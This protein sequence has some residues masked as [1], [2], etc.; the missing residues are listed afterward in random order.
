MIGHL[1]SLDV[2]SANL[3]ARARFHQPHLERVSRSFAF[4]I[5]RLEPD[6]RAPVGLGY[7]V[8][9]LLD[10]IEDAPWPSVAAQL[11]AFDCFDDFVAR[12]DFSRG[13]VE[14]WAASF[15]AVNEGE[16]LL[17]DD[18][19]EVFTELASAPE[20]S[21]ML[22]PILSMSRGMRE[23]A[24][25]GV[26]L[27][28]LTDVNVYCFFVAGV[29]GE[30]LTSL[31]LE[32]RPIGLWAEA[33][34]FG[35][36]LQKINVLKD[37][38]GDEA[39]GRFL[40]P[41]RALLIESVRAHAIEAFA[42]LRAQTRRDYRLFC[43]WALY[44]G[45][46]TIPR[47][48]RGEQKL[49]RLDALALGAKLELAIMDNAR[50]EDLFLELRDEAWPAASAMSRET[51]AALSSTPSHSADPAALAMIQRCYRGHLNATEL[52]RLLTVS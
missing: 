47:L 16:R 27:T 44:L 13:S 34:H 15:P 23:F 46:A 1:D 39:E 42:Y 49:S 8:C 48:R 31:A 25:R 17:L 12:N 9:R 33:T 43:A 41:D 51:L 26:R 14:A 37:Q 52:A 24:K 5:S 38:A 32:K 19:F 35:L 11:T 40:V 30:L 45:L 21:R 3:A 18:A 7:L 10:T 22:D 29:V 28:S 2:S 4:G 50:L 6:L 36:F 20:R